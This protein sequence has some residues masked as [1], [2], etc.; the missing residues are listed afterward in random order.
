MREVERCDERWRT[1]AT[2]GL[3]IEYQLIEMSQLSSS[4]NF[5]CKRERSLFSTLIPDSTCATDTIVSMRLK[6]SYKRPTGD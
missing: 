5:V 4:E 1:S 2:R 3:N 6:Y